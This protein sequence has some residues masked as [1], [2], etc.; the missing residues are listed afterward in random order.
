V[1]P[2]R[3]IHAKRAYF[4][5]ARRRQSHWS[6]VVRVSLLCAAAIGFALF[7]LFS[8]LICYPQ[9]QSVFRANFSGSKRFCLSHISHMLS[10]ILRW[11][12]KRACR[13]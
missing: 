3:S 6:G 4:L 12:F 2:E 8:P 10:K 11:V 9:E 1:A 5:F 13:M 7:L